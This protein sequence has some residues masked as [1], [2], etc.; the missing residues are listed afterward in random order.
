MGHTH[1]AQV[2][3][4]HAPCN[5]LAPASATAP[6]DTHLISAFFCATTLLLCS[7]CTSA[8]ACARTGRQQQPLAGRWVGPACPA[9][10]PCAARTSMSLSTSASTSLYSSMNGSPEEFLSGSNDASYFS[11]LAVG[12][13]GAAGGQQAHTC[14]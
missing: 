1:A 14:A 6:P 10:P 2:C 8:A 12:G 13:A 4:L 7:S 9:G 11:Y 5:A 3:A